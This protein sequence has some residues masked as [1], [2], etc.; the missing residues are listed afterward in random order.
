MFTRLPPQINR[1][2][3]ARQDLIRHESVLVT[4]ELVAIQKL[5]ETTDES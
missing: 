1:D 3:N 4:L 5:K 2:R